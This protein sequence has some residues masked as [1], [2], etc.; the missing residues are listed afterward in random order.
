MGVLV[1]SWNGVIE[2]FAG[3][4]KDTER[5]RKGQISGRVGSK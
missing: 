2:G 1:S 3:C 4:Q 5:N